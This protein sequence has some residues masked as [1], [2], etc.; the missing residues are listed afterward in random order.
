MR[1]HRRTPTLVAAGLLLISCLVL[2]LVTSCDLAPVGGCPP[3]FEGEAATPLSGS[4][5]SQGSDTDFAKDLSAKWFCIWFPRWCQPEL[6]E[7]PLGDLYYWGGPNFS[8]KRAD[9]PA[10]A[11]FHNASLSAWRHA[12]RNPEGLLRAMEEAAAAC[13][14]ADQFSRQDREVCLNLFKR[15][16]DGELSPQDMPTHADLMRTWQDR[17]TRGAFAHDKELPALLRD[18]ENGI[19]AAEVRKWQDFADSKANSDLREYWSASCMAASVAWWFEFSQDVG[20]D[21]SWGVFA[22]LTALQRTQNW[23]GVAVA[24]LA[25]A[26]VDV[27]QHFWP[28]DE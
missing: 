12:E 10:W 16:L 1:F 24:S 7:D 21:C 13:G 28:Q 6:P 26:L 11:A 9:V 2:V 4:W 25:G 18:L 22:D 15:L 8:V 27:I 5:D 17:P 23:Q 3:S 20:E 14:V 19:A